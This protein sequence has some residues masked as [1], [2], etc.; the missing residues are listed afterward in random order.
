MLARLEAE[1]P[2]ND[3]TADEAAWALTR[4]AEGGHTSVVRA[5]LT[6]RSR[7]PY[8]FLAERRHPTGRES[9]GSPTR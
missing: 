7:F 2:Q 4:A 8:P 1:L 3:D 6:V 5:L 9:M